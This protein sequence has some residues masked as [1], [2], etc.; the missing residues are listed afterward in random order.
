MI[1]DIEFQV[2]DFHPGVN[3]TCRKG[4]KWANRTSPGDSLVIRKTGDNF[5]H[6]VGVVLGILI[7]ENANSIPESL[8]AFEHDASCR[9]LDGI[10]KELSRIYGDCLD[11]PFT[12]VVFWIG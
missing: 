6:D 10:K 4:T 1:V 7:A 3:V 9:D 5:V 12:V 8:L 11:E 2:M